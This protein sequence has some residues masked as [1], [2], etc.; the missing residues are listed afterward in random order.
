MLENTH[1]R[2]MISCTKA[3]SLVSKKLLGVG[4]RIRPSWSPTSGLNEQSERY[5]P[6]LHGPQLLLPL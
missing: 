6:H 4:H 2:M 5:S 1:T 3:P